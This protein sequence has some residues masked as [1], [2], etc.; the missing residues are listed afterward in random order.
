MMIVHINNL[1]I[2]QPAT[3]FQAPSAQMCNIFPVPIINLV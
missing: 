2:K 1:L 3:I